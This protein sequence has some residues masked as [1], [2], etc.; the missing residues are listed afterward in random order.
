MGAPAR[1][2]ETRLAL[3]QESAF[4]VI[5]GSPVGEL[6]YIVSDAVNGSQ[7]RE[8]DDTM[9][10]ALRGELAPIKTERG[11][12]GPI[13]VRPNAQSLCAFL[14][15]A[16][17]APTQRRPAQNPTVATTRTGTTIAGVE[18]IGTNVLTPT[19]TGTLTFA[20]AGNTLA[21]T[22]PSGTA[23]TAI[24]VAAGGYFTLPGSAANTELYVR[25]TAGALPVGNTTD[26]AITVYNAFEYRF[27]AGADL[28]VGMILE[29]DH[30]TK[31]GTA[32]PNS[33]Y[34]RRRGCRINNM[35][36]S[37]GASGRGEFNFDV[38]GAQ[39][40]SAAAALDGTLDDFGHS[41][42][43]NG[44]GTLLVNRAAALAQY[45]T[46][47]VAYSNNLDTSGRAIGG[48]GVLA[49]LEAGTI[50]A[51]GSLDAFFDSAQLLEWAAADTPLALQYQY[52]KGHG[53]GTAGN[54]YLAIDIP[55]ALVDEGS[56]PVPGPQGLRLTANWRAYRNAGSE[57]DVGIIV[58]T[59]RA[60]V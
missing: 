5:P 15:N 35:N 23:G 54:E 60:T 13:V 30:G 50:S 6:V 7:G 22:A 40:D 18:I 52:R 9:A 27:T 1:G 55:R 10:G 44:E 25:V 38:V 36:I 48:G 34:L 26:N 21:W 49:H 59:S 14:R 11:V 45:Q 28:L 19:G 37:A 58:R 8:A 43:H 53:G 33:R 56:V 46:F 16:I 29:R 3:I 4:N 47:N 2:N 12:T 39:F 17:G 31:I 57:I 41:A 42:F 20:I 24:N 32:S 51:S